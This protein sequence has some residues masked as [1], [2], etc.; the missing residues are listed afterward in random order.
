[1]CGSSFLEE[2]TVSGFFSGFAF[3]PRGIGSALPGKLTHT[4]SVNFVYHTCAF[5]PVVGI[6]SAFLPNLNLP[7]P[8]RRASHA[9]PQQWIGLRCQVSVG[10]QNP[11]L[12]C[13]RNPLFDVLRSR[14]AAARLSLNYR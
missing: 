14:F 1:M 11:F 2:L 5:S 9:K 8:L 6:L 12:Q 10:R 4:T 13:R 7:K 3:G